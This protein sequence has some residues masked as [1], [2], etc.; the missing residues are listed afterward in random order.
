M[1]CFYHHFESQTPNLY[2]HVFNDI[3]KLFIYHFSFKMCIILLNSALNEFTLLICNNQMRKKTKN[4][5]FHFQG[6]RNKNKNSSNCSFLC[7]DFR[8]LQ[9]NIIGD[10]INELEHKL[11]YTTDRYIRFLNNFFF[12]KF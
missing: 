12:F 6:K 11:C 9:I 10:S 7:H 2:M 8:L 3:E 1:S 5:F 4:F